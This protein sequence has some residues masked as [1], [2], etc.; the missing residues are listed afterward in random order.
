MNKSGGA[1]CCWLRVKGKKAEGRRGRKERRVG[2]KG[3]KEKE[4]VR[5]MKVKEKRRKEAGT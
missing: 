3:G 4:V 2:K 1:A 5:G